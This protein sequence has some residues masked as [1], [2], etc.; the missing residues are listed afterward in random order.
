MRH[1]L[2]AM[3][4]VAGLGCSDENKVQFDGG[5]D[6]GPD[7]SAGLLT[8]VGFITCVSRC[9]SGDTACVQACVNRLAPAS[10]TILNEWL[11]CGVN[12][13]TKPMDG[14]IFCASQSDT[15]AAC[16][17]CAGQQLNAAACTAQRNACVA[18]R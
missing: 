2:L 6:A 11:A 5:A 8:C 12:E 10:E 15:S 3:L 4:V 9:A 13:C 14:G 1:L 18:D 16:Q 17:Q 7:M